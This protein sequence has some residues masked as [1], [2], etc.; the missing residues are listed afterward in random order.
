MFTQLL[1]SYPGEAA[2]LSSAFAWSI[3][4]IFMRKGGLK[5]GSFSFNAFKAS[6]AAVCFLLIFPFT[7][8]DWFYPLPWQDWA[9]LMISAV[10]GI[11]IADWFY[12]MALRK[13]GAMLCAM[14]ACFFPIFVML[15]A[16]LMYGEVLPATAMVGTG[17]V[18]F[19]VLLATYKAE[20]LTN[21]I[22][23]KDLYQ[24]FLIGLAG[25]L[26]MAIAIIMIRDIYRETP[27][28]W[29]VSFRFLFA[30]FTLIPFVV[31]F[32]GRKN[33]WNTVLPEGARSYVLLGSFFGPFLA[34]IFW[35]LGYKYA[36]AGVAATLNKLST[37]FIFI[38]AAV[39]LKEPVTVRRVL[40]IILAF[41]GAMLVTKS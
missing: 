30:G 41:A 23:R 13:L 15:C 22:T 39:F 2:A 3:A 16:W 37:F 25:E 32:A 9:R 38:L 28:F 20:N 35:F 34:T 19:A 12:L 21:E 26:F 1:E 4:V 17:I 11:T 7:G 29:V 33:F 27:V 8:L 31:Y 24:G 10:V 5:V 18:L 40:A 6:F 36:L 14:L